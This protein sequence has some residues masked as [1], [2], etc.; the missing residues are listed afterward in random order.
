ME[1][2]D[3]H[4]VCPECGRLDD[5]VLGPLFIVTGASCSGKIAV[6]APLA[7][8]LRGRCITF[9]ADLLLDSAG[10]LNGGQ[11]IIWTAFL[12]AWLAVAHGVAQSGM[13]TVLLGPFIPDHL[14][15]LPAHRW[16]GDIRFFALDC[17][18]DL[19]RARINARPR[20]RSRDTEEQVEF[21]QW[22][23]RNIPTASTPATGHRTTP[24]RPSSPGSTATSGIPVPAQSWKLGPCLDYWLEHVVKP[25]RRTATVSLYETCIRLVHVLRQVLSVALS[26]AVREE[27]VSRNVARLVE[28]PPWEPA[29]VVP[30]RLTRR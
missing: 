15:G 21:G 3:G 20:W 5:A 12:D 30:W 8:K 23:R 28:L 18:D 7:R 11:P 24:P 19:R 13:P 1:P 14:W 27:L 2:R 29:E 9:D 22:L 4:A 25:T 17:P 10:A 26:R 16:T 6:L